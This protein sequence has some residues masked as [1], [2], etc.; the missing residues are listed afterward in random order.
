MSISLFL[1]LRRCV[2]VLALAVVAAPALAQPALV[3]ELVFEDNFVDNRHNWPTGRMGNATFTLRNG[4]YVGESP[5]GINQQQVATVPVPLQPD[6]D[7][8]IE[9]EY[10]TNYVG[11]LAWGAANN[12]NMQVFGI[13][14]DLGVSI[15]GWENGT[16]FWTA[17]PTET[18]PA[19]RNGDWN[20]LRLE[21]RGPQVT[22]FIN[23][24]Q[25]GRFPKVNALK[26]PASILASGGTFE[27]AIRAPSAGSLGAH[28]APEPA[29]TVD[30]ILMRLPWGRPRQTGAAF[31]P[32]EPSDQRLPPSVILPTI[33]SSSHNSAAEPNCSY[34]PNIP[35]RADHLARSFPSRPTP[36]NAAC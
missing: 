31:V 13:L 21:R 32:D 30:Q 34:V 24:K 2:A 27:N 5:Q 33:A 1:L 28:V 4:E 18:S 9:A 12:D 26:T 35:K 7:F 17:S 25:V 14:P 11:T 6:D 15:C 10:R 20:T 16:F 22:Y 23:Y 29:K 3:P 19:V 8:V 36:Q